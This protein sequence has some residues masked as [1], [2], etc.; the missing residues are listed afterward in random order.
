MASTHIPFSSRSLKTAYE[1]VMLSEGDF[2]ERVFLNSQTEIEGY[3]NSQSGGGS[4][5]NR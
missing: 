1:L 4:D 5:D 2:D 3:L